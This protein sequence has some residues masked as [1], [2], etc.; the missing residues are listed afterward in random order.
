MKI[1]FLRLKLKGFR[2]SLLVQRIL[3]Y[4]SKSMSQNTPL[5]PVYFDHNATTPVDLGVIENLK[6]WVQAFGNPSSIHWAGRTPKSLLRSSRK[7]LAQWVKVQPLELVFTSG[8]SE[9]NNLALQGIFKKLTPTSPRNQLILSQVEHPSVMK[10]ALH[11]KAQGF[12]VDFVPVDR[13]GLLDLSTYKGLLSD[14]TALVSI[15]FANNETGHIFPIKELCAL[16]HEVGARFHTDGVQALGKVD[17]DLKDLN[18]DMASFS[19]HKTYALKGSGVL[20]VKQG[21]SLESL[22]YG[23]GQERGRRAGTENILSIAAIGHMAETLRHQMP[24]QK[25]A[26][27]RDH[28]ESVVLKRL[29]GVQITGGENL[30]LPNTSSLMIDGI[31]GETL[32]MNLD[33]KGYAVS[34]GAACSAGSPE[35][36][37]VLLA[38]GFSRDEAQRSLRVSFGKDNTLKQVDSFIETLVEIV[39][40]LRQLKESGGWKYGS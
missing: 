28:F 13:K 20:Y 19:S 29:S 40:R 4:K 14:K 3:C 6:T 32:L 33:V 18:V 17:L 26:G 24:S 21:L 5:E 8:G 7:S 23:G 22:I 36:S 37:P 39:E 11:L 30:R 10:T 27:L 12:Q 16:A 34:T 15:M 31:D 9:A 35:P 38:M 1:G 2:D 25:C